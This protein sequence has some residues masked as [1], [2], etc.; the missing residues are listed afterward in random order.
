[1][2]DPRRFNQTL[3]MTVCFGTPTEVS[4]LMSPMRV[5]TLTMFVDCLLLPQHSY[6]RV[7]HQP[8]MF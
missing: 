6:T 3:A 8:N 4:Q 7:S 2:M 5:T 1:M